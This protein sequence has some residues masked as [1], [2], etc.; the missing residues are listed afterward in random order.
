MILDRI[1]SF[2]NR[3]DVNNMNNN[4]NKLELTYGQIVE[5]LNDFLNTNVITDEQ[6]TDLQIALNDLVRR[7]TLSVSDINYNL[8]KIQLGHLA[9]DVLNAIAGTSAVNATPADLSVTTPKLA[10]KAV[11]NTKLSDQFS[12]ARVLADG[13]DVTLVSKEGIYFINTTDRQTGLPS[14]LADGGYGFSGFLMVKPFSQYHYVQELHDLTNSGIIYTRTVKNNANVIW[15]SNSD[16][17]KVKVLSNDQVNNKLQYNLNVFEKYTNEV[18][19]D[20]N[21]AYA[22]AIQDIRIEGVDPKTPVKIWTLAR[23]FGT[24]NYRII[25]G[26][27]KDGVWSTLLDTTTNFVV[28]EAPTGA[29]NVEYSANGIT[30]KAR[31]DYN[32]IPKNDRILDHSA[33]TS[34]PYF[35][36]KPENVGTSSSSGGAVGAQVYNQ[37]LNTTDSVQFASIKT[38]ALDVT[39]TMPSGTLDSPPAVNKGDMWLD[40]TDS[41]THPIVRVML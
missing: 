16:D 6:Y 22:N 7:G 28:T 34:E 24:W 14:T 38:D 25:L 15:K 23:A 5:V 13:E 4:M 17:D 41:A 21:I 12:S 2:N 33:I 9:D 27:K 10:D 36:I 8:G 26:A 30:L 32:V 1:N 29:T 39:G 3:I 20:K 31:I 40:T 37:S 18:I 35:I 11:N 19:P